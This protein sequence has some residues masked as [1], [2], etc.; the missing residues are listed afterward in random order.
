[1]KS[2][3]ITCQFPQNYNPQPI[4]KGHIA[5]LTPEGPRHATI[6]G[7]MSQLE[8]N[9]NWEIELEYDETQSKEKF[10]A[11]R[12]KMD[13]ANRTPQLDRTP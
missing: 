1:M 11:F 9:R 5:I 6:T 4:G 8:E 3:K 12:K 10:E 7:R 2:V 13:T